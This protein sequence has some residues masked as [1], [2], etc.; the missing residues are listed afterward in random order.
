MA[1]LKSSNADVGAWNVEG[2]QRNGA[3]D[4]PTADSTVWHSAPN[5]WLIAS[6]INLFGVSQPPLGTFLIIRHWHRIASLPGSTQNLILRYKNTLSGV[7]ITP[8][9]Y[10][11]GTIDLQSGTAGNQLAYGKSP[12]MV[13]G[14][15]YK[16]EMAVASFGSQ[17]W[18]CAIFRMND[19]E[20]CRFFGR[21]NYGIVLGL[22]SSSFESPVVTNCDDFVI[23]DDTGTSNCYWND[24]NKPRSQGKTV[25]SVRS[26]AT[27]IVSASG[28]ANVVVNAPPTIVA[29]DRLVAVIHTNDGHSN[30]AITG[31]PTGWSVIIPPRTG[32]TGGGGIIFVQKVATGSEPASYTFTTNQSGA[33]SV[34]TCYALQHVDP[35][36]PVIDSSVTAGGTGAEAHIGFPMLDL[37]EGD[38]LILQASGKTEAPTITP[39]AGWSSVSGG[40]DGTNNNGMQCGVLTQSD[41]GFFSTSYLSTSASISAMSSGQ[42]AFRGVAPAK[43]PFKS[44]V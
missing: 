24:A 34:S 15:W 11:D 8:Q 5:S 2:W 38:A 19:V 17:G 27:A 32:T 3:G 37:T 1:R 6:K 35:S 10:P 40:N 4:E 9:L 21:T 25:P 26:V 18:N 12:A 20:F 41:G 16:I 33:R 30:F 13:P 22:G 42:V 28:S 36:S 7:V 14:T 43:N 44:V 39:A 31:L 23:N 29:G